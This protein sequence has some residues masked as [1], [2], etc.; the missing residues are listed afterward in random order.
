MQNLKLRNRQGAMP[1]DVA[2]V[3]RK[4]SAN[5]G[6]KFEAIQDM[7][8]LL[9]VPHKSQRKG[10]ETVVKITARMPRQK[11][12]IVHGTDQQVV[13]QGQNVFFAIDQAFE[14]LDQKLLRNKQRP[15][16]ERL[17]V[18]GVLDED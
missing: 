9:D 2:E 8:V 12:I 1:D 3:L 7:D 15:S 11:P 5:L 16:H 10:N 4:K 13:D 18:Q 14:A 17:E 6:R